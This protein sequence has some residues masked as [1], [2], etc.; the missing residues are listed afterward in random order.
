MDRIAQAVEQDT[1]YRGIITA[2]RTEPQPTAADAISAAAR[3]VAETLKLAAIV[4]YTDSGSTGL[5]V[6]RER[7]SVPIVTL[8]TSA[9]TGRRLALAWGLHCVLVP[10]ASSLD[11]MV[12]LACTVAHREG[13]ARAGERV[14]ITAG[15]PLGTPGTTNLLRIAYVN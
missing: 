15:V 7:P 11:D 4:C 6:A 8:T 9:N 14:L 3:S 1:L 2:Q 10:T 12:N 13:F 5:R